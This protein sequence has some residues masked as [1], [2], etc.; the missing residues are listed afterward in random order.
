MNVTLCLSADEVL[1]QRQQDGVTAAEE[2]LEATES[3]SNTPADESQPGI[4]TEHVFTDPLGV[5]N[6]RDTPSSYTQRCEAP[7]VSQSCVITV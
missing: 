6:S 2:A 3:N 5:Q 4:Y 1:G 7:H